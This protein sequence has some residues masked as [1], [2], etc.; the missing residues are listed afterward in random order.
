MKKI[1]LR[2]IAKMAQVSP[3]A[4]SLVLNDKPNRISKEKQEEIRRLA[5]EHNYQPNMIAQSLAKNRTN[6]IGLVVPDIENP[7]FAKLSKLLEERFR[8]ESYLTIIVNSD[9][10]CENEHLLIETL[11]NRGVDGLIVI[12]AN[13]S[14]QHHNKVKKFLESIEIPVILAD[15]QLHDL[16]CNQVFFNNF[17]GGYLVAQYLIKLG[18]KKIIFFTGNM[19]VENM[20]ERV[21]GFRKAVEDYGLDESD[22]YF[23]EVG[24]R[25]E[26]GYKVSKDILLNPDFSAIVTAND[27]VAYGVLK[28]AKEI[29]L[30]FPKDK[31]IIGYDNLELST[32]MDFPLASVDQSCELLAEQTSE[33]MAML[34]EKKGLEAKTFILSPQLVPGLSVKNYS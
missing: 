6:T 34:F 1:Q 23:E 31:S 18:H 24:F 3:T 10:K 15:R 2:D 11:V 7:Y 17:Q 25:F 14:Y 21:L 8:K 12:L 5:K 29:K 16:K 22:I 13:E 9:D 20:K 19:E 4:V 27:M 28:K 32:I 33:I 30:S 26:D